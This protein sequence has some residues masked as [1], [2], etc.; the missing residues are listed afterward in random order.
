[1][2]LFKSFSNLKKLRLRKLNGKMATL[3]FVNQRLEKFAGRN[4]PYG[5]I[6]D[7]DFDR[8]NKNIHFDL[9]GNGETTVISI[10]GYRF[11]PCKGRMCLSWETIHIDG[12]AK[13]QLH[14]LLAEVRHIEVP[15]KFATL[16][17]VVL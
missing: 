2:N 10:T 11:S 13:E 17:E 12:P 14:N 16:L 7:L 4:N 6:I 8:K 3:Y 15:K 1:M 5:R 9:E